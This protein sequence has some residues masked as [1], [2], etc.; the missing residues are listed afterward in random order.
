MLC[1]RVLH[2]YKKCICPM[3]NYCVYNNLFWIFLIQIKYPS[4]KDF[5]SYGRAGCVS[6][7]SLL[8]YTPWWRIIY[9]NLNG[10]LETAETKTTLQ[11]ISVR[12]K[13]PKK[14]WVAIILLLNWK[15]VWLFYYELYK[16]AGSFFTYFF[17]QNF[18]LSQFEE[19]CC[20]VKSI[21]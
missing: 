5:K 20:L 16:R 8:F 19:N 4:A 17:P 1:R 3:Y 13:H 7:I 21:F 15:S 14:N 12:K 18:R 9:A 2:L 11:V 10:G 6:S